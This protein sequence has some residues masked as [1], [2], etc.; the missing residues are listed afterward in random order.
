MKAMTISKAARAAGVGV[1]TVR[2][3][4][5]RGLIARPPK[6]PDGGFRPYPPETIECVRFIR[7]AQGLGFSLREIEEL[8]SLRA[9][10]ATD[11][12]QVRERAVTKLEDVERRIG[13]L[14]C[15]RRVLQELIAACP[16]SGALRAC[17]IMEA[18][19]PGAAGGRLATARATGHGR[20]HE[21]HEA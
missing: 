4:E 13:E 18:L 1:E 6:P 11:C 10:P 2:F 16:G 14:E 21:R 12:G 15:F 20:W 9:D 19:A 8:L 7:Q 5:R 3:Y 17:S